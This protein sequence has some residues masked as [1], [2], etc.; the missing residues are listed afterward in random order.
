[1]SVEWAVKSLSGWCFKHTQ[2]SVCQCLQ[3]RICGFVSPVQRLCC[4]RTLIVYQTFRDDSFQPKEQKSNYMPKT[5]LELIIANITI[6]EMQ[7]SLWV[8]RESCPDRNLSTAFNW[9]GYREL[10]L[11]VSVFKE[12][13]STGSHWLNFERE[14]D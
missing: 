10:E 12:I 8:L 7:L 14:Y 2:A 6:N 13:V 1:M 5:N 4:A 11:E 3:D 9:S